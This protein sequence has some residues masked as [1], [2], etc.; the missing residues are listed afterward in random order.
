M[1]QKQIDILKRANR[2]RERRVFTQKIDLASND[3]L[4][5]SSNKKILRK[6]CKKILKLHSHAPKASML[7]SGYSRIHKILE[8]KLKKIHKVESCCVVGSGFLGNLAI[9]DTLIRKSD[10][11]L[12][13]SEYHASGR[14]LADTMKHAIYFKHNNIYDLKEKFNELIVMRKVSLDSK[15]FIAVEGVYSMSGDICSKEILE[16]AKNLQNINFQKKYLRQLESRNLETQKQE[17]KC[18]K[19]SESKSKNNFKNTYLN[20]SLIVDEAHSSGVLG[21]NLAGIYDYYDLRISKND[22]VLGTLSKAYASYGAYILGSKSSI[23]FLCSKARSIIFTTSLGIFDALL[24]LENLKY[25]KKNVGKI[26]K[27][28]LKK[29]K[30]IKKHLGIKLDSLI[31]KIPCRDNQECLNLQKRLMKYDI[32]VGAIRTPTVNIAQLRITIRGKS[33]YIK[34]VCDILKNQLN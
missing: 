27:D 22:I 21:Q 28:I 16:F 2:F 8:S 19:K 11:V 14:F 32:L 1:F 4:S 20:I 5:L 12:V 9:F 24:A 30:I 10:F 17:L 3:Y 26:K 15:I 6:V 31:L 34:K 33:I 13:D 25:I 29:Q 23:D 7:V 18:M